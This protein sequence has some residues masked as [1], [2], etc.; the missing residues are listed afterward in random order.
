MAYSIVHILA[1]SSFIISALSLFVSLALT[2]GS[3]FQ[4]KEEEAL[5]RASHALHA[6]GYSG[7]TASELHRLMVR[8]PHYTNMIVRKVEEDP[9]SAQKRIDAFQAAKKAQREK[10][11]SAILKEA[12]QK[13][14][15][16]QSA[17]FS[18]GDLENM[19]K[20]NSSC[21]RRVMRNIRSR[22]DSLAIMLAFFVWIIVGTIF[23]AVADGNPP[24]VAIY[25]A[26]SSLSTAGMVAVKTVDSQGH[27]IFTAIFALIGVPL[28]GT[29]LGSF[30]NILV[31]RY[32]DTQLQESL[33]AK[34]SRSEVEYLG[35][36]SSKDN[37]AEVDLA[38]YIEF[39]LLRLGMLDRGMISDIRRQFNELDKDGTGYVSTATILGK[40][41]ESDPKAAVPVAPAPAP[42][43]VAPVKADP[44]PEPVPPQA[45]TTKLQL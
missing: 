4:S 7:F 26:V 8:H 14:P 17:R 1:G 39:T 15:E 31:D 22:R 43:E 24:I 18:I 42:A 10:M 13:L 29:F 6:D 44:A 23:S 9:N 32:N 5:A 36:L 12:S 34:F 25:Y 27:V 16:F 37:E 28:Y 2:R 30:A 40:K 21:C 41:E 33:G 38:E 20:E 45:K 11:A 3:S 35:H 19:E